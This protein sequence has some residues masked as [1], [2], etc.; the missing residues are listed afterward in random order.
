MRIVILSDIHGNCVALDEVLSDLRRDQ[1]D[2]IVCLGDAIQGGPQPA[3]VVARLREL[4]C[5]V[6]MGNADAW[7]VTGEETGEEEITDQRRQIMNAIRDWSLAQLAPS[8]RAFIQAFRPTVEIPLEAGRTL[9][10]FHGSPASFDDVILPDISQ[11]AL[12]Q[13]LGAYDAHA[14]TGG[15]THVQQLRRIGADA[16]FFFNPGSVGFAYSHH[17]SDAGFQADPWAEYALL[18][19][20]GERLAVEFRRVPF[21]VARLIAVYRS[22]GRPHADVAIAQ[23]GGG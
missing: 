2:R 19:S 18:T 8:D 14:M 11:E 17:Q 3:E 20:E 7:L 13:Y 1:I 9:L 23:Y 10:C 15:H 22:S 6:V 16:R 5:P 21:N 4:G 12:F